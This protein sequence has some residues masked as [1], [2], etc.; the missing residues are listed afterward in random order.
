MK[1][2]DNLTPQPA[3]IRGAQ[4]ETF[5]PLTPDWGCQYKVEQMR[6]DG[7]TLYQ[8]FEQEGQEGVCRWWFKDLKTWHRY[9]ERLE[10]KKFVAIAPLKPI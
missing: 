6:K 4:F 9:E 5:S 3:W 10:M 2:D 8:D 1:Y 7:Y